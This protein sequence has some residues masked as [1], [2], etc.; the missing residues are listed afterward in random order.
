[1][2]QQSLKITTTE[3]RPWTSL[4]VL[5]NA[6]ENICSKAI[7]L[8]VRMYVILALVRWNNCMGVLFD[9]VSPS[10]ARVCPGAP[11]K[12]LITYHYTALH[13][14]VMTLHCSVLI[15]HC[16]ALHFQ[17]VWTLHHWPGAPDIILFTCPYTA[18]YILHCSVLCEKSHIYMTM[19]GN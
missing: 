4:D 3:S 17:L 5:L 1:M 19:S 11:N 10:L 14:T 7:W 9:K 8:Y 13:C 18:I 12:I 16:S 15:V 2:S 6:T